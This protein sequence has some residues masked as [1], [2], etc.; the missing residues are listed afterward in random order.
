M[1]VEFKFK[2]VLIILL[3]QLI[4]FG[5]AAGAGYWK[6]GERVSIES[7]RRIE[8][9]END[10]KELGRE[11]AESI[12]IRDRLAESDCRKSE[13][14]DAIRFEVE[15]CYEDAGRAATS[16]EQLESYLFAIGRI[17]ERIQKMEQEANNRDSSNSDN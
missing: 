14:V 8:Q 6:R 5:G 1:K 9:L 4:L 13:L 15:K 10:N 16:V 11:L 12:E 17:F 3:I 7:S 2:H